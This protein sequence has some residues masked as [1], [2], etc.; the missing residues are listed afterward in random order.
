MNILVIDDEPDICQSLAGF[1]RRL[2][3]NVSLAGNGAEGLKTF[4]QQD[5]HLIIT[6][7]RMPVLDGLE[8]LKRIKTVERSDVDVIVFTGHGDMDNAI[9]ALQF[10]AFDYLQKPVNVQELAIAIERAA[11]YAT[12]RANYAR[13]KNDFSSKVSEEVRA[14]RGEAERLRRAYLE[15]IGLGNLCVFSDG[16]RQ[17]LRQAEKYSA[18]RNLAVLIEGESGTGK[19]LIARYIHHFQADNQ[20]APFVPINC[21]ACSENLF[22]AELFGH[23]G[24]AYTGATRHGRKGKLEAAA[25]GTVFLDEIGEMPLSLQ[26]KLLRVLEEKRICRL[27]G[28]KEIPID[29]RILCATNKDLKKEVEVG[30]FRLD[31]YYRISVGTLMV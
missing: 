21:G 1:L 28:I 9:R 12:L 31:L 5:I 26:V 25:G 19:E 3:H 10:G 2:G 13:L 6:D 14:C 8:L 24:G 29:V 18:D 11:E 17:V 4:H 23:E 27:G 20:L 15:E 22:E 7:L 30:A 16:M